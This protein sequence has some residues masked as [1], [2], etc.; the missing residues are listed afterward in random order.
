MPDSTQAARAS[1]APEIKFA[2]EPF[3]NGPKAVGFSELIEENYAEMERHKQLRKMS[4]DR[5]SYDMM[6]RAGK[7]RCYSARVNGEQLVGYATFFLSRGYRYQTTGAMAFSDLWYLKPGFR[8][9][10]TAARMLAF[11]ENDMR[12]QDVIALYMCDPLQK[13]IWPL[14]KWAGFTPIETTYEKVLVEK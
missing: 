9:G 10:D 11:V 1:E 3:A 7:M 8:S 4:L 12:K 5:A 6:D 2:V 14:L 13:S